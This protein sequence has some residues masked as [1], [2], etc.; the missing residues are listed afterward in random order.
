MGTT[1]C[2]KFL[3]ENYLSGENSTSAISSEETFESLIAAA[4]VSLRAYYGKEN[5]WDLTE[6]GTDLYT[7]GLD[8]RSQGFCTY[9][10]FTTSE[11]QE[12]M[13]AMW[14]EMYKALNTCNLILAN[15]DDVPYS[16]EGKR[17][18][19]RGEVSFLRAHYLWLISEIWGGVHFTTEPSEEVSRSANRTPVSEFRAQIV[20]DLEVALANLPNE[21]DPANYGR[22]TKPAAEAFLARV[23]LYA[24]NYEKASLHAQN[25]IN[26]YEFALLD[27]WSQIW[28]ID[29]IKND[30]VI[31]AVNYSSDP[32]TTQAGFTDENGNLY[33]STGIIQRLGGHTGHVMYEIRYENL[34]WGLV[35]DVENGRGFQRWAPTKHFID[36]YNEDIDERFYG[37][38]KTVWK[39]NDVAASPKWK[40]FVFVEGV[41]FDVERELWAQ[42]IFAVGDTSII[43]SKKPVPE[44][45]KGKFSP[46]DIF[47]ID[48]VKANIIIDIND[49]YLPDGSLNDNVI[50]RQFYFPISK[51][52]EDPTR[53]ELS[54]EYSKRDA[55][56]F[57][58]SEMYL[59]AAEAEMKLGNMDAATDMMNT[60]RRARAVEGKEDEMLITSSDLSIDFILDER[61]RELATEFQRFFDLKRTGKLVE[62]I[63]AYNHDAAP[64][65]QDYHAIRFV[66]QSQIDA[67][68]DGASY[69]NPG[70]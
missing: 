35:R 62:R 2:E 3:E 32:I 70:Y 49:M 8:N 64:N 13:K 27:D 6:A 68:V 58:I 43:F 40:P 1:G 55:F 52:Y 17:A 33:N 66:P 39:A 26:N 23:H 38:F 51:K 30:E 36:L 20:T 47:Y 21:R 65:I 48:P 10:S 19:R 4:Y 63:Q 11:E 56:V 67:M 54:T 50:N 44:S 18:E 16:D 41:K 60:L 29:N 46:N 69:Q 28:S 25:V 53:L 59:I 57:R 15:I 12:R 61:A 5:A 42:P 22:I 37:S 45:E 34:G 9:A 31:W 24:E 7:W 14:R